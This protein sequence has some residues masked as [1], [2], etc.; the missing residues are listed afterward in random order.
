MLLCIQ[1]AVEGGLYL[2]EVPELICY[3][4]LCILGLMERGLAV[5]FRNFHCGGFLV[6]V[7][8]AMGR[9]EPGSNKI[10]PRPMAWQ[11]VD[12]A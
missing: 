6:T 10:T 3:V 7:P 1:Q 8:T 12:V 5:G 9:P 2:L 11:I 4:L